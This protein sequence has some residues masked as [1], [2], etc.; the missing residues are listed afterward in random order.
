MPEFRLLVSGEGPTDLG[1]H[2]GGQLTPG[3]ML[4]MARKIL[5][6]TPA[7][8][9]ALDQVKLLKKKDLQ[10]E[11]EEL[12]KENRRFFMQPRGPDDREMNFFRRNAQMLGHIASRE[13][14]A[15][16]ILF[17]DADR[18]RSSRKDQ[19]ECKVESIENGFRLAKYER[20]VAMVPRPASEAWLLALAQPKGDVAKYEDLPGNEESPNHPKK[21]LES[22]H[23][24]AGRDQLV[25]L[26]E[27][28]FVAGSVAM[29]SFER[30]AKR[31]MVAVEM[32]RA[33]NNP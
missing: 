22:E 25:Q 26:V 14:F 28:K 23:G 12:R 11:S 30:F 2:W 24:F 18:T 10:Q 21:K 15:V 33:E 16:A 32:W 1:D 9:C 3:P 5:K 19:W 8:E 29:P 13:G 31:L 7:G 17:R 20:G 27:E 6:E 4:E